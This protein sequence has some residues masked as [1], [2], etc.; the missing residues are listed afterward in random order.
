M[1]TY[2]SKHVDYI[3]PCAIK[4]VV[5]TYKLELKFYVQPEDGQYQAPKHVVVPHVENTLYSTNKYSCLG[6]VHTLYISYH[7]YTFILLRTERNYTPA[8]ARIELVSLLSLE[9]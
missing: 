9:M 2:W 3:L 1:T 4:T 5:L 6:C 8:A 7:H